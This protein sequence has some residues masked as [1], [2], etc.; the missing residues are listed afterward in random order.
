MDRILGNPKMLAAVLGG[1]LI[2]VLILVVI[3][4]LAKRGDNP[5]PG[6]T[7]PIS[8]S[9][10]QSVDSDGTDSSTPEPNSSDESTESSVPEDSGDSS[11]DSS[12]EPVDSSDSSAPVSDGVTEYTVKSGDSFSA[13]INKHYNV[14]YDEKLMQA[15]AAYNNIED[16]NKLQLGQI[17]K[18]PPKEQLNLE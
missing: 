14:N 16:M 4:T 9:S 5:D 8:Q 13:I 12:Q 1:A 2:I 15:V 17:I 11:A 6:S 18:L 10:S 3:L 7:P